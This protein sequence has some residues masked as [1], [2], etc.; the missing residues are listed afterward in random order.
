ML[1]VKMT[2]HRVSHFCLVLRLRVH[3]S[4]LLEFDFVHSV[5]QIGLDLIHVS[6]GTFLD[7]LTSIRR[8]TRIHIV[9]LEIQWL[10]IAIHNGL[11][12]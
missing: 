4:E 3:F 1:C 10:R 2:Q 12:F 7:S 9:S 6:A 8:I 11:N 5:F